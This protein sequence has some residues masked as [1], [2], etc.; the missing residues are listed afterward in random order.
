MD[1]LALCNLKPLLIHTSMENRKTK[2]YN[3][4]TKKI[5]TKKGP[6]SIYAL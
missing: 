5:R 2:Q 3:T 1:P 6:G 4:T